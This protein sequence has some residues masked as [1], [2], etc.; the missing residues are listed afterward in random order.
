LK[1]LTTRKNM[2]ALEFMEFILEK[3]PEIYAF[4]NLSARQLSLCTIL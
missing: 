3:E 1:D 2:T 4:D